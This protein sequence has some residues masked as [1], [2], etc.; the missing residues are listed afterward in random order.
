MSESTQRAAQLLAIDEPRGHEEMALWRLIEHERRMYELRVKPLVE[1]LAQ[2]ESLKRPRYVV[3]PQGLKADLTN[4]GLPSA[5]LATGQDTDWP[6]IP[7][8]AVKIEAEESKSRRMRA[9]LDEMPVSQPPAGA[10]PQ[11][12]PPAD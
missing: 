6:A 4:W 8:R 9:L 7:G 11:T 12:D 3:I 10:P 1:R 2:I 5:R